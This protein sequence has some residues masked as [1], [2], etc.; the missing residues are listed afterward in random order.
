MTFPFLQCITSHCMMGLRRQGDQYLNSRNWGLV[1]IEKYCN[2]S[3]NQGCSVPIPCCHAEGSATRC[4]APICLRKARKKKFAFIFHFSGWALVVHSCFALL[5]IVHDIV[6]NFD[7]N[8][9]LRTTK[10]I[11]KVMKSEAQLVL[12]ASYTTY[13]V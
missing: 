11:Q 7:D 6:L 8:G 3:S 2:L 13:P 10:P 12:L 9:N 4:V 5:S 1:V